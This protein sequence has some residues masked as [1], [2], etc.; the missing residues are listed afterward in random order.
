MS[1]HRKVRR[2][3][4]ESAL[5]TNYTAL[6]DHVI[7]AVKRSLR[8]RS[9]FFVE[10]DL[11]AHYNLAWQALHTKLLEETVENQEG[12]LVTIMLRRAIDDSGRGDIEG[13]AVRYELDGDSEL[14]VGAADPDAR[15]DDQAKLRQ[16][17]EA[18]E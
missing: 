17:M 6:R 10:D 8:R 9:I 12:F 1:A 2:R 7:G 15:L 14:D 5:Q 18:L 11:D 13:R 3:R 4:A 16:F